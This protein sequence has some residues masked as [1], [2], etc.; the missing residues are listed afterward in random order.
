MTATSR[1]FRFGVL[2]RSAPSRAEWHDLARKAQDLGYTSFL[3]SDHFLGQFSMGA[4][5]VSAAEAAPS[6]RV[7]SLV[8]D[9]DFRHPAVLAKE[10]AT[11]DVLTDGR[12]DLGLGAGWMMSDYEQTGI[13]FD[14]P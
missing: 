6:L 7:G 1:P 9:T 11:I 2:N 12:F 3:V 5:L 8:Y 10:A 14:P 13:S 4:A